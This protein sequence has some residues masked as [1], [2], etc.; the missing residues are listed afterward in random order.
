MLPWRKR[1]VAQKNCTR[2]ASLKL[3]VGAASAL[4]L[5]L[6]AWIAAKLLIVS[7]PLNRA[8]AII[9]LSGSSTYV[10]RT[11]LAAQ[12]YNSH[13]ADRIILTNDNLRSGWL[14]S[15]QRNPYF[16]ERARW[17]LERLGVPEASIEVVTTPVAGTGDEALVVRDFVASRNIHS[18]LVVTSG[19]HSRRAL[20]T[21]HQ[22]LFTSNVVIGMQ[23][24]PPGWQT[25]KPQ[26]WF[27][28]LRGWQLVPMEYVKIMYYRLRGLR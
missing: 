1:R 16:Y 26:I 8:D 28:S 10:E 18:I 3:V 22:V 21:F 27:L 13:I 15:Q 24:A 19:Y 9:V 25:P 6:V 5:W 14:S 11:H 20:W 12:L 4:L 23:A 2:A 7:V 17:E